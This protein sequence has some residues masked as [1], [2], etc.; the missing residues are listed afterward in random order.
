MTTKKVKASLVNKVMKKDLGMKFRKVQKVP[1]HL[2]S[3][4]N[5]ILR[6]QWAIKYL[7]LVN[8]YTF[9]NIDESWLSESNFL[10]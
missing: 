10:R 8:N 3:D 4:R 9:L 6:Q 7:E 5:I 2:N 1:L